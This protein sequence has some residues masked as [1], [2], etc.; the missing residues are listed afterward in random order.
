[1][2]EFH[3]KRSFAVIFGEFAKVKALYIIIWIENFE[4][5]MEKMRYKKIATLLALS[6]EI[7]GVQNKDSKNNFKSF[8]GARTKQQL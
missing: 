3:G 8:Q 5:R 6:T 7:N 1:M 4:R 2:P